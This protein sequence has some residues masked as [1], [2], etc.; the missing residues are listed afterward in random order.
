MHDVSGQVP[1]LTEAALAQWP[2]VAVVA[3]IAAAS[4]GLL[5]RYAAPVAWS[6][7]SVFLLL[8]QFGPVLKLGQA[9]MDISP[10]AHVPKLP[11]GVFAWTSLG[12][13]TLLCAGLLAVGLAAFRQRDVR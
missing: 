8:G 3:G 11:G 10:F 9:A 4:F 5:P 2:A 7:L 13:L 12:W 6:V 1:R